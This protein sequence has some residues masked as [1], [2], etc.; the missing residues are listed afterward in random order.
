M[1]RALPLVLAVAAATGCGG[2]EPRANVPRPPAPVML[3]AAVHDSFVE[4]SPRAVGAGPIEVVVS[5]LSARPQRVTFET[6][7]SATRSGRRA[8][9]QV[10]PPQGTGQVTLDAVRGRYVVRVDDRA[11]RA[12]RVRVG[13]RRP[14]SQ[15][16][17][18]L[19]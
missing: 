1:R 14:S 10:I 11:V 6:A 5:N 19:P 12:A 15:N 16:Q 3:S 2:G 8:S 9:T 7:D 18:L 17:L 13:P 4:V